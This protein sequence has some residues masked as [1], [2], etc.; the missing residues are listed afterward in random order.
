MA[1]VQIKILFYVN[2]FLPYCSKYYFQSTKP[3]GTYHNQ[4]V[5]HTCGKGS[6][7]SIGMGLT[8]SYKPHEWCHQE[9]ISDFYRK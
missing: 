3:I 6:Q 9:C 4:A 2:L 5:R 7:C 8:V 1:I